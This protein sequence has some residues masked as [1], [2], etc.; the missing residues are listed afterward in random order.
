[1]PIGQRRRGG[2]GGR[3]GGGSIPSVS[4]DTRSLGNGACTMSVSDSVWPLRG[5]VL[6]LV[7]VEVRDEFTPID[8]RN[9]LIWRWGRN[10]VG[11]GLSHPV[12]HRTFLVVRTTVEGI[13]H[14]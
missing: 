10:K 13:P 14:R 5:G 8:L 2:G 9:H 11:R 6:R 12:V 4:G 7:G 3:H 1:M